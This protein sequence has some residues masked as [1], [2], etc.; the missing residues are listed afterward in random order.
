MRIL[1]SCFRLM[2]L[3]VVLATQPPWKRSARVDDVD[4][5][6]EHARAD[7]VDAFDRRADQLLDQV[8]VVDHQIEHDAHVGAALLERREPMRF[9]EARLLQAAC[10]GED[11]GIETLEVADLQRCSRA[12]APA[13][14]SSR[15]S[16]TVVAI[17]FSIST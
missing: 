16:A 13:S 3:A 1:R 14:T 11:R 2:R 15:A 7:R 9:D 6:G 8:D 4:L 5:A 10:R 17:G 12:R